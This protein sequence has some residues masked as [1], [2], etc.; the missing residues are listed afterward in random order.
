M[1]K[2]IVLFLT[3]F[4]LFVINSSV[5]AATT[6]PQLNQD[7]NAKPA[8]EWHCLKY[9]HCWANAEG[10][11][12]N[13]SAQNG[14]RARITTK[15][16]DAPR[17][18]EK[19]TIFVCIATEMGNVCTS[20]STEGDAV[21]GYDGQ[22][23]LAQST[24]TGGY[25]FEGLFWS[26]GKTPVDNNQI[27]AN[28]AGKLAVPATQLPQQVQTR[29]L[30]PEVNAAMKNMS[31]YRIVEPLE[32]QDYTPKGIARKWLV[33]NEVPSQTL[34]MGTGGQ[35]QGTFT[36]EGALAQCVPIAWDPYGIVFDSQSL[37][38]IAGAQV[39]LNKKQLTGAY[40]LFV[41]DEVA[42][43]INPQYTIEDGNFTFFVPDGTYK[44]NI[45][46][47][48]FTYPNKKTLA[49]NVYKVYSDIYH[50]EDIIQKGAIQHRDVPIDSLGAPYTSSVK[51]LAYTTI[52][53]K[54]SHEFVIQGKVSHP[55]TIIKVYGKKP[56]GNGNSYVRTKLLGTY[57][58]NKIGQFELKFI[59]SKLDKT[60]IIGD[61]EFI[62]PDYKNLSNTAGLESQKTLFSVEPI[63]NYVE[64]IAYDD[65]G[66]PLANSKVGVYLNQATKS[67]Y[68]TKTDEK[69]HYKITSEYLPPMSYSLKYLQPGGT[70]YSVPTT[71]YI[72]QNAEYIEENKVNTSTFHDVSGK[73]VSSSSSKTSVGT[74]GSSRTDGI[75]GTTGK[76]VDSNGKIIEES[77][78][79]SNSGFSNTSGNPQSGISNSRPIGTTNQN[80]PSNILMIVAL[81]LISLGVIGIVLALYLIK[82]KG[83]TPTY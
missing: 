73:V 15:T 74:T 76:A 27:Y 51:V 82:K 24:A 36:F 49:Q 58:A 34:A 55:L 79:V 6:P 29:S 9:E 42:S 3:I 45:S 63:L 53:S 5:Y 31:E 77:D 39:S 56:S 1:K 67:I 69:G 16:T 72:A 54:A 26:D 50:D 37:E 81:I 71:K 61:I 22:A 4:G 59:M 78:S 65:S 2:L 47:A 43:I 64:G 35:Q 40:T 18:G 19:S 10:G 14:H 80:N 28:D 13:C 75:S 11:G 70:T 7:P 44:L 60:E 12:K 21:L 33:L 32:W 66:K 41:G 83:E 20:G 62:K 52:L 38:P 48:G 57:K 17:K 68:E 46:K 25:K 30:I 23:K 8:L